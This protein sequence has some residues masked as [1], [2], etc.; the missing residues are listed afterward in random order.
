[1]SA[2]DPRI[3]E[4]R[5]A[6]LVRHE[7]GFARAAADGENTMQAGQPPARAPKKKRAGDAF[8]GIP[9]TEMLE[10]LHEGGA[11]PDTAA[12]PGVLRVS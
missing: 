12:I 4:F 8:G 3:P 10:L 9:V 2:P 5:L 11:E 7:L 1:V 6:G